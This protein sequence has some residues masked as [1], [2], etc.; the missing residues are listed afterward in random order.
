MDNELGFRLT[1]LAILA[2]GIGFAVVHR[3]CAGRA[4]DKLDRRLEG[5][6]IAVPL[7]VAG[8][9]V[10]IGLFAWLIRPTAMAW[11]SMPLPVW[12][13]WAGA[14]LLAGGMLWAGWVVHTLGHNL[15]DTVA[16]RAAATL[17]TSGPY[18]WIRNPLYSGLPPIGLS[19]TL[20]TASAVPIAGCLVAFLL[21]VRR[22]RKEESH[23]I[24]R[25][26]D[27]YRQYMARTGRFFPL[28]RPA[29]GDPDR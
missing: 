22:T 27:A 18:R 1:A 2:P 10:W 16:T 19:L 7:R 8:F 12:L 11:S 25:F 14:P 6:W 4:G 9:A 20:L 5:L 26:G 29:G 17:V 13:R 3:L 21:L 23:L 24:A 15:T 28:R